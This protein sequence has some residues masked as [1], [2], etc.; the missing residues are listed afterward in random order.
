MAHLKKNILIYAP[1][2]KVY[3][4][5]RDPIRWATWWVGL[6]EPEKVTG[7]G[8][9]GTIVEHSYLLAGI[10]F[11]VTSRVLED[12]A[13]PD[14]CRWRGLIEGPFDGTQTWNYRPQS[15]GTEVSCEIEYTVPGMALG[16]LV[17][18]LIIERMMERN[19][20]LTMENLKMMCEKK[21]MAA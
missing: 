6:G 12:S 19:A 16:K 14:G 2:E 11:P 13:G 15:G 4:F 3:A 10:R 20:D 7:G 17:D 8:E 18:R 21:A 5:A 1:V 9:V